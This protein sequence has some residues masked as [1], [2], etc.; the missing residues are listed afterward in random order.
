MEMTGMMKKNL[1]EAT[2]A[3][4]FHWDRLLW[5]SNHQMLNH[6]L[7]FVI[8]TYDKMDSCHQWDGP[9]EF[10]MAQDVWVNLHN[11]DPHHLYSTECIKVQIK[12]IYCKIFLICVVIV[13]GRYNIGDHHSQITPSF[14]LPHQEEY[15][16]LLMPQQGL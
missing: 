3:R 14:S 16:S 5:S 4:K 10:H 9:K 11:I 7:T 13:V 1:P 12:T 15:H 6:S 2:E 8:C